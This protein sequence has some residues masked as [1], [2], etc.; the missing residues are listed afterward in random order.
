LND[1]VRK[2]G[3]IVL[4]DITVLPFLN[5]SIMYRPRNKDWIVSW[6]L[7][8]QHSFRIVLIPSVN[9]TAFS[10]GLTSDS[11]GWLMFSAADMAVPNPKYAF[12]D[13]KGEDPRL[14]QMSN[15]MVFVSYARRFR[16]LPE[17]RM[18]HAELFFDDMDDS[19]KI[20]IDE[21]VDL[22]ME[23]NVEHFHD[24]KNWR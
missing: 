20:D 16:Q 12:V 8:D 4:D 18:A 22:V 7:P 10:D 9:K 13:L 21:I 3:T 17:I 11:I 14:F 5:P 23:D 1:L 15:G 2:K 24:Q 19:K 6:R